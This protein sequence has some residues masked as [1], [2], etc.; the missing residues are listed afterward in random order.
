MTIINRPEFKSKYLDQWKTD[1]HFEQVDISELKTPITIEFYEKWLAK[2]EHGSMQYLE[3]H[4][5]TKRNPRLLNQELRSALVFTQSY[6]N[7]P[8]EFLQP[9]PARTALYA[10][11]QDYHFWLKNKVSIV[12]SELQKLFPEETFL[13]FVDS[14]PLM[15]RDMGYQSGLGWFGKN[16]CLIHPKH[17]SLFFIAEIL[18]SI[19]V[20]NSNIESLPDFCGTCTRCIDICPTKAINS[21]RSLKAD[22]C[23]SYL[24]IESKTVPPVELRKPIGDW[25]FGCDLCQTICPWNQKPLRK[26]DREAA[27]ISTSFLLELTSDRRAEIVLFFKEILQSSGKQL[28]KKFFGSPLS[29]AHGFGLKRNALIVIA[30][31]KL[32]ELKP[33][34]ERHFADEKLGELAKWT[35]SQLNE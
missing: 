10:H 5:P 7:P 24:T 3:T 35:A 12:M 22:R 4:L 25:F 11:T 15:E 34:V 20:D 31:Q 28:Q 30:N 33:E 32:K 27:L 14:G 18:C 2:N 29:R 13:P 8:K 17:G 6:L 26:S 1:F 21:D 19:T 16:S 9:V 23:I